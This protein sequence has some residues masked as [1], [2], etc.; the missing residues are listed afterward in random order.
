MKF[1]KRLMKP[2]SWK[3]LRTTTPVSDVFGFDRGTPIDRYFIDRFLQK[4]A[5]HIRGRVLEIGEDTYTKKFGMPGVTSEV[6]HF[7]KGNSKATIIGDLTRK[8][9]LPA[10]MIDCFICT[11]TFNFIYDF[12]QAIAGAHHVLKKDGV[13]LATLAGLCQISKY[14]MERWGDYWRFT[15]RSAEEVFGEVFGKD[16]ISV[17]YHGNVLVATSLLHG[18]SAEELTAEELTTLD[19]VYQII[20]TV[21]AKKC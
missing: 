17:A 15:T 20:I 7:E 10:G 11:Q 2:V 13:L 16:N 21:I 12:K 3:N 8:E 6:L 4:N 14:D 5:S 18:L 19:P 9:T 1:L